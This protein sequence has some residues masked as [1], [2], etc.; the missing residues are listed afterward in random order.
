VQQIRQFAVTSSISFCIA[1]RQPL[2]RVLC[3]EAFFIAGRIAA[4]FFV[5][6]LTNE[7]EYVKIKTGHRL[8][9]RTDGNL[10]E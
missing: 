9:I 3:A 10:P 1:V 5:E 2:R 6:I 4:F 7:N 8:M